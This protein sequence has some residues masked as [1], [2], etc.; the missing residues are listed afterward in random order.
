MCRGRILV[1]AASM[2]A[3]ERLGGRGECQG[4]AGK[5][6]EASESDARV[7]RSSDEAWIF[8]AVWKIVSVGNSCRIISRTIFPCSP[9]EDLLLQ[10]LGRLVG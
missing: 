3:Q 8:D 10:H 4:V 1:H 5:V 6:D 7:F 2:K 9:D